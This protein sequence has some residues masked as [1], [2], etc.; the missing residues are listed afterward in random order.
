MTGDSL[1]Q[2]FNFAIFLRQRIPNLDF[3]HAGFQVSP[4][5]Q[6][7]N[8][9]TTTLLVVRFGVDRGQRRRRR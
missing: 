9:T 7:D 3:A 6:K 8:V 4:L 5:P 1:L 2:C